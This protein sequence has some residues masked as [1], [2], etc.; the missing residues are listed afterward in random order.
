MKFI[1]VLNTLL[2]C[3]AGSETN[4]ERAVAISSAREILS[5]VANRQARELGEE[6][7]TLNCP[8]FVGFDA[9]EEGFTMQAFRLK[10]AGEIVNGPCILLEKGSGE[11][12]STI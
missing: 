9:N 1:D 6:G 3:A 2:E 8:L 11:E 10:F 12:I 5:G 7:G 4:E